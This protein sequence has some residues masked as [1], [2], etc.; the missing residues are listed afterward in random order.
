METKNRAKKRV[1]IELIFTRWTE[2]QLHMNTNL[3]LCLLRVYVDKYLLFAKKCIYINSKVFFVFVW[4]H[5]NV[6]EL[7]LT[8]LLG[9]S[10]Y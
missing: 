5:I 2:T 6:S 3:A 8:E 4:E 7:K 9:M 10:H 1:N